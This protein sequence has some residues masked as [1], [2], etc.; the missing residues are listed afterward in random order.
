MFIIKLNMMIVFS[1]TLWDTQ[2]YM[3]T[4]KVIY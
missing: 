3:L 1:E 2:E 4:G